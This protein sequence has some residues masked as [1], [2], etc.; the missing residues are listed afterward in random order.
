MSNMITIRRIAAVL[1]LPV[2]AAQAQLVSAKVTPFAEFKGERISDV[3]VAPAGNI[4]AYMSQDELRLY[5]AVT[6]ASF[7]PFHRVGLANPT[8]ETEPVTSRRFTPPRN[9]LSP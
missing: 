5:N 4:I 6:H 1:L 7:S 9:A 3:L 2:T 8:L